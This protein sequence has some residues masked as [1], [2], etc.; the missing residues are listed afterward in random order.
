MMG[1]LFR[2]YKALLEISKEDEDEDEEI[3][4]VVIKNETKLLTGNKPHGKILLDR[5]CKR[6]H[7][8]IDSLHAEDRRLLLKMILETCNH[9]EC[10]NMVTNSWDSDQ[11]IDYLFFLK[12]IMQQQKLNDKMIKKKALKALIIKPWSTLCII[13]KK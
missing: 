4:E 12:A 13:N 1:H 8:L 5:T 3:N 10:C 11:P 6:W 9:N 7:G 2:N